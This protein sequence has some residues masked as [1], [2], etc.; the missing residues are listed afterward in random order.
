MF[1]GNIRTTRVLDAES[2]NGYW[3]TVVAEDQGLVP[4]HALLQV[5]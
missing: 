4:Q 2:K 5:S 3:L 1:A